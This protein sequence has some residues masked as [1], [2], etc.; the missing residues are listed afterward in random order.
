MAAGA[1]HILIPNL[2]P[3]GSTPG[4]AG[5]SAMAAQL[6]AAVSTYNGQLALALNAAQ[7]TLTS[8]GSGLPT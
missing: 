3:L 4:F 8:N 2:P 5:Q 1:L 6:N 7:A